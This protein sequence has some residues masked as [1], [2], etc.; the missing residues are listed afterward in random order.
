MELATAILTVWF[1]TTPWESL[2]W[3]YTV[4]TVVAQVL[5]RIFRFSWAIREGIRIM[6]TAVPPDP[7]EEEWAT[8]VEQIGPLDESGFGYTDP[9]V[10]EREVAKFRAYLDSTPT[11]NRDETR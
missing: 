8:L 7:F 5:S 2:V 10:I 3:A 6:T 4:A 9:D 11:A 1:S